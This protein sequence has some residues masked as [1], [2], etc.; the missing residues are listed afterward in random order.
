MGKNRKTIDA[1][2][3]SVARDI[4]TSTHLQNPFYIGNKESAPTSFYISKD[5]AYFYI[6]GI[7]QDSVIRYEMSTP[8]LLTGAKD[9]GQTSIFQQT[10]DAQGVFLDDIGS[11]MY[12]AN[13]S[14]IYQY[15]LPDSFN[16]KSASFLGKYFIPTLINPFNT[17]IRDLYISPNGQKL[18]V[19][20]S[21]ASSNV[22]CYNLDT[23]WDIS[24]ANYISGNNLVVGN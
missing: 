21:N 16:T 22:Y 13:T 3:L 23:A 1:H 20:D 5:G 24:T 6:L 14:V 15:S 9:I 17:E 18:F 8:W 12:V 7:V 4:S 19:A 2:K 11:K 10:D